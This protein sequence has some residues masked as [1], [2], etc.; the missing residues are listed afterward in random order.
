MKLDHCHRASCKQIIE[1]LK[2]ELTESN[3]MNNEIKAAIPSMSLEDQIMNPD[4]PKNDREWWASMH[5]NYL[6]NEVIAERNADIKKLEAE[7]LEEARLN[8]MGSEREAKLMA[9][10][11][12]C[13]R[14]LTAIDDALGTNEGHSAVYWIEQLK[15]ERDQQ[16]DNYAR[17]LQVISARDRAITRLTNVLLIA[18]EA[19]EDAEGELP[20]SR[21]PITNNGLIEAIRSIE[22]VTQ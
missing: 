3:E 14:E 8:G 2:A 17:A 9:E 10:R 15:A 6:R 7:L 12:A 22:E 19:L 4:V 16:S 21:Y 18:K 11:D 1:A 20:A 5:I 13:L